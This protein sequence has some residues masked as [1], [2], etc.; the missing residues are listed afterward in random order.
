M[1][2]ALHGAGIDERSFAWGEVYLVDDSEI[3]FPATPA[4]KRKQEERPAVV[5]QCND[6]CTN[7]V[8]PV[9][10]IAPIS[11]IK[12][13][14]GRLPFDLDVPSGEAGLKLP[15]VIHVSLVQ[16]LLKQCLRRKIGQ[17][18]EE[19]IST[20]QECLLATVLPDISLH[21]EQEEAD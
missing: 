6:Y 17:L 3:C 20:L 8:Y 9:V 5:V 11:S 14:K 16:P 13:L 12:N 2:D 18:S 19:H 4:Q 10:L 15:S 1:R 7:P 21:D